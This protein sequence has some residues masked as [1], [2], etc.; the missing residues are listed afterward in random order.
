[1]AQWVCWTPVFV[2]GT[3]EYLLGTEED[4]MSPLQYTKASGQ[5]KISGKMLKPLYQALLPQ[6]LNMSFSTGCFTNNMDTI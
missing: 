2:G 4:V 1:M 3:L 5:D 6:L